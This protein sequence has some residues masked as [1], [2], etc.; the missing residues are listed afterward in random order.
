MHITIAQA[1]ADGIAT[2]NLEAGTY[3]LTAF[4]NGVNV[5]ANQHNSYWQ[6]AAFTLQCQLTDLKIVV[7][8]QNGVSLPFV[9]LAITYQYQPQRW[10]FSNRKCFWSNRFFRN[11]HLNSTLNRDKLHRKCF[12]VQSSFQFRQ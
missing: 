2:L 10:L 12:I 3:T 9:N 11:F 6:L 8:N 5:G 1:G 7:Q 4:W